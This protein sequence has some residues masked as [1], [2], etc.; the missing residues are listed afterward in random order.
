MLQFLEPLGLRNGHAA[1]LGAPD[2][3]GGNAE[4]V[5]A[6]SSLTAMPASAP[7]Q[8]PNDLFGNVSSLPLPRYE[9]DF[10]NF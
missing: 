4:A 6:H 7:L 5:L 2:V 10:T 1:E 3:E 9:A 8:K